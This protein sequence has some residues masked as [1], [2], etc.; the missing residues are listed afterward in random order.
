MKFE[1]LKK[2]LDRSRP[3]TTISMHVPVG[4]IEKGNAAKGSLVSSATARHTLL[5]L[6]AGITSWVRI[7]RLRFTCSAGIMPPEFSSATMPSNPSS[8]RS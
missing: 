7:C 1:R 6:N 8:S 2:R 4:V 3:M 5:Y